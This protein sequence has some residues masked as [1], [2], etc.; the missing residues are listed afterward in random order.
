MLWGELE[1]L[2]LICP[3]Q[4]MLP[5]RVETSF[6]SGKERANNF[7]RVRSRGDELCEE[8]ARRVSGGFFE[9]KKR[10]PR[11]DSSSGQTKKDP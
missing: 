7:A 10:R 2:A 3:R 5:G 11:L 1:P 6:P 4:I 9:A 8:L